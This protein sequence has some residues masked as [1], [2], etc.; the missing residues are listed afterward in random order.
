[1]AK[2]DGEILKVYVKEEAIFSH[3]MPFLQNRAE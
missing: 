1:M 2:C 3:F